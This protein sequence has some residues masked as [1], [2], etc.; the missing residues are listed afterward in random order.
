MDCPNCGKN[1]VGFM[2]T[3]FLKG[4]GFKKAM[5]GFF[6]CKHCDTLLMQKKNKSGIAQFE[7]PF[8]SAYS[9]FMVVLL[10]TIWG[11]FTYI[12]STIGSDTGWFTI[13]VMLVVFCLLFFVM[14]WLRARYWIIKETTYEEH[15]KEIES[16]KL[17]T[18][19]IIAFSLFGIVA[20]ASFVLL[21]KYAASLNLTPTAYSI[22]AIIYMTLIMLMA[23]GLM[24][25]LSKTNAD[26]DN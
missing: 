1:P 10:G 21:D 12:E 3:I 26:M 20:I 16:Q 2:G 4:G 9:L 15:E 13:P 25:Y 19:G 6:R 23:F 22:A 8:W 24:S 5:Q 7:K 14:D 17:S 18:K 11:A